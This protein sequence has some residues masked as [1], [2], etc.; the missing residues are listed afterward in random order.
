LAFLLAAIGV[1]GMVAYSVA[2]RLPELGIRM[3]LG[4]SGAGVRR[5]VVGQGLRP[6]LAGAAIGLAAGLVAVRLL[7]GFLF[8]IP[9]TDP[10]TF[11]A[12]PAALTAVA[13]LAAWL[14]AGRAAKLEPASVLRNE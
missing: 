11:I 6:V 12:A 2:R 13:A 7:A 4:A 1:Y 14:P 9:A 8:G 5:L 3:A 10:V